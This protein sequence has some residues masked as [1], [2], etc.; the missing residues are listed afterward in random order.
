MRSTKSLHQLNW[1]QEHL[2]GIQIAYQKTLAAAPYLQDVVYDFTDLT[3]SLFTITKQAIE[4]SRLIHSEY[5]TGET[6]IRLAD[7]ESLLLNVEK[8]KDAILFQV[9]TLIEYYNQLAEMSSQLSGKENSKLPFD[10][11][12]YMNTL[13]QYI[14]SEYEKTEKQLTCLPDYSLADFQ[15]ISQISELS[16]YTDIKKYLDIQQIIARVVKCYIALAGHTQVSVNPI[17]KSAHGFIGLDSCPTCN[18]VITIFRYVSPELASYTLKSLLDTQSHIAFLGCSKKQDQNIIN[19]SIVYNALFDEIRNHESLDSFCNQSV[20][21]IHR[22]QIRSKTENEISAALEGINQE[23]IWCVLKMLGHSFPV[24]ADFKNCKWEGSYGFSKDPNRLS[25]TI[26]QTAQGYVKASIQG[27]NS[28]SSEE[29]KEID[30]IRLDSIWV[31]VAHFSNF[32]IQAGN[33]NE[34]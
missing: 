19:N 8:T 15:A 12:R 10:T 23:E 17:I 29:E 21:R 4:L 5:S 28:G 31:L 26:R 30:N 11:Y 6:G 2:Q 18:F 20:V 1:V 22:N 9:N 34:S 32:L 13:R 7:A 14:D 25:L 24:Q 3:K 27:F 16:E 33:Q